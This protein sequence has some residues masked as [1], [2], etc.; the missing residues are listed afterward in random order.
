MEFKLLDERKIIIHHEDE[1]H[2][3]TEP[4]K[5]VAGVVLLK[6]LEKLENQN[7]VLKSPST[8]K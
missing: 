4:E 2:L 3:P 7:T 1:F 6:I 8:K 5:N